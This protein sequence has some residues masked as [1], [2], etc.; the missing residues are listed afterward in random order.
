MKEEH[1]HDNILSPFQFDEKDTFSIVLI[2]KDA[3]WI[4]SDKR[5]TLMHF[6]FEMTLYKTSGS[7]TTK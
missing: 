4:L 1:H 2:N 7:R 5:H 6:V 3:P